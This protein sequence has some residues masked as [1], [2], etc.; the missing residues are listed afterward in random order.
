MIIYLCA[1]IYLAAVEEQLSQRLKA[2]GDTTKEPTDQARQLLL[3]AVETQGATQSCLLAAIAIAAAHK[4]R[5]AEQQ[6]ATR[7]TTFKLAL[8]Q[9]NKLR[10]ELAAISTLSQ[11]KLAVKTDGHRQKDST[12]ATHSII[13]AD[14]TTPLDCGAQHKL[15]EGKINS[16][17]PN[18]TKLLSLRIADTQKKAEETADNALELTM[19]SSC[20]HNGA[21][22][23]DWNT[24][25]GSCNQANVRSLSPTITQSGLKET[26]RT[27]PIK[28]LQLYANPGTVGECNSAH[29]AAT[30]SDKPDE[31][32]AKTICHALRTQPAAGK[33]LTLNGEALAAETLV[34]EAAGSCLPGYRGKK[35]L[36][37]SDRQTLTKF[38]KDAYGKDSDA[39][40]AKFTTLKPGQKAKIHKGGEV[41]AVDIGD[42]NTDGEALNAISII[43]ADR[44]AQIAAAQQ[45]K[46]AVDSKTKEKCKEDAEESKCTADKDCEHKDGKCQ[47][48]DGVKVEQRR[49][50]QT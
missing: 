24:A 31:Y 11:L 4:A 17:E 27:E 47:V 46:A 8:T 1:D 14:A 39:F 32:A 25:S 41:Q 28:S 18:P 26:D 38:L 48:K 35:K 20:N 7:G 43:L 49:K 22:Y 40:N 29:N 15:T 13:R 30:E 19:G 12:Q 37:D 6:S 2:N 3:A 10:R 5:V 36:S 23:A 16:L 44:A 50:M 33:K 34:V 9:I 21:A 45:T 42:V